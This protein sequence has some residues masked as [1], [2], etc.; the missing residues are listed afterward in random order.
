MATTKHDGKEPC[1]LTRIVSGGQTGVDRAALDAAREAGM[2]IGGWCPKGRRSEDGVI[3]PQYPLT[4]TP[5]RSYAVRTEWN[6]RD[7]DGT[8]IIVRNE[9]SSGTRLTLSLARQLV[10]P[11]HVVHLS[12]GCPGTLFPDGTGQKELTDEV[13][14][15]L[16]RHRICTLN[17]AG[18]RGSSDQQIYTDARKFIGLLFDRI[19]HQRVDG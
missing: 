14:C 5:A 3:P 17:I 16:E 11:V 4:E 15:W 10:R 18:P 7:S 13:A 1:H 8:L 2:D 12:P 19:G 6:V 9:I